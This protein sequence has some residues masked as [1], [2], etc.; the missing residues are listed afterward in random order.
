M[1][2]EKICT[3]LELF[4][5]LCCPFHVK[6]STDIYLEFGVF[7]FLEELTMD[8]SMAIRTNDGRPPNLWYMFD[9]CLF[10]FVLIIIR[11]HVDSLIMENEN[12]STTVGGLREGRVKL[13]R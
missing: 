11:S 2:I 1:E 8:A 4:L 7:E 9:A 5:C 10:C 12:N 3:L 13:I 6:A